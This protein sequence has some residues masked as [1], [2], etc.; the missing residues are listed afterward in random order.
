MLYLSEPFSSAE[1]AYREEK[2]RASFVQ[3]QAR[4]RYRQQRRRE[5]GNWLALPHPTHRLPLISR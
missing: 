4:R 3:A 5:R 1:L 2:I